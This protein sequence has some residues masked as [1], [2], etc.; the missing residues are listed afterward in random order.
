MTERIKLVRGDT[1]PQIRLALTNQ[2]TGLP[3]SLVGATVTL[4][5]R[6]EG[7][8]TAL[9]SRAALISEAFASTGVCF[10]SWSE[11]DLDREAGNYEGEIEI[12]RPDGYRETIF[13]IL[14]FRIR[15]DFA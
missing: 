9:F 14:K 7:A 1:S 2:V 12:T 13:D 3:I 6:A 15:E 11:G 5:F 10:L 8:E 4:H